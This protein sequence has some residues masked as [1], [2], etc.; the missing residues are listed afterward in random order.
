MYYAAPGVGK[1]VS[2]LFAKE[3]TSLF[4]EKKD[5]HS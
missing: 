2:R 4:F 5:V 3:K 1:G